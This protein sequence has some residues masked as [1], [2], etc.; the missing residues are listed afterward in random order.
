[1]NRITLLITVCFGLLAFTISN[2]EDDQILTKSQKT[3]IFLDSMSNEVLLIFENDLPA[4]FMS[5]IFTPVCNTGECLP[6]YVNMY[7]SLN[8]EFLKFDQPDGEIL[9][10]LDHQPFSKSDYKLLDE[11]L[12]G[13]DPRIASLSHGADNSQVKNDNP[14]KQDSQA[15]PAPSINAIKMDKHDMVD[16]ISGATLPEIKSQFVPGALYTTYTLWGLANDSKNK[17]RAYSR[18]NLFTNYSK[19]LIIEEG[20][21]CRADIIEWMAAKSEDENARAK[22]LVDL[23]DSGDSLIRRAALSQMF[24]KYYWL[25]EVQDVLDRTFYGESTFMTQR[26]IIW[27][28]AYNHTPDRTLIKLSNNLLNYEQ[29]FPE[30]MAVFENK[31]SFPEGVVSNMV[32]AYPKLKPE[33]QEIMRKF[34]VTQK[35]YFSKEDWALIK[36]LN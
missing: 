18:E 5:E 24:F 30:M 15:M 13:Q 10:K 7:W 25:P 33:N 8:G 35:E 32:N 16:G 14:D 1:M 3:G 29:H 23:I 12:R 21:Q 28:W 36:S 19:H 26:H 6:V 2:L 22:V 17:M 20:L 11:I 4:Y 27:D 9:T 31:T 34:V